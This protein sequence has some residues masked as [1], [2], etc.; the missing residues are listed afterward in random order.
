MQD[1]DMPKI[2]DPK[3]LEQEML[4]TWLNGNYYKRGKGT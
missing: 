4:K 3:E 2:Y 1:T